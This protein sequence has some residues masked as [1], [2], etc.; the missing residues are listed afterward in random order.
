[1]LSFQ[2]VLNMT[3]SCILTSSNLFMKTVTF[4]LR[5]NYYLMMVEVYYNLRSS[6]IITAVKLQ[7]KSLRKDEVSSERNVFSSPR[8]FF[9]FAN[10]ERK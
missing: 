4:L 3:N 6:L 7:N 9:N 5:P 1:M 10:K 2:A 8:Q